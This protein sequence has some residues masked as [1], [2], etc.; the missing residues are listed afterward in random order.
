MTFSI[1]TGILGQLA[2][3]LLNGETNF[4]EDLVEKKVADLGKDLIANLISAS[5]LG[6]ALQVAKQVEGGGASEFK[7]MRDAWLNSLQP[8]A[9]H[10]GL[11]GKIGN[12]FQRQFV[13]ASQSQGAPEGPGKWTWSKSRREWLDES[14]KHNWRSQPRDRRGRWIKGRLNTI[15]ISPSA[16][17]IRNKRRRAIRKG[18]REIMRGD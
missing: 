9:P 6:V 14:W 17:K 18:V 11:L 15:Y 10:S 5:P 16:R 3:S 4:V 1:V 13:G 2:K 7:R 8:T 12:N